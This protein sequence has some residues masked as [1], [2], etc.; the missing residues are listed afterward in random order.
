[1]FVDD[2]SKVSAN[3]LMW[4]PVTGY[5]PE[6][7][8]AFLPARHYMPLL[9]RLISAHSNSV[10]EGIFVACNCLTASAS[11]ARDESF[12][13]QNQFTVPLSLPQD[14]GH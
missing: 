4:G 2:W 9:R 1:M 10:I 11:K 12:P 6:V 8:R 13:D 14:V 3:L 5:V 7:G